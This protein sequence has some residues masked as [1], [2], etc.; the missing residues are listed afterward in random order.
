MKLFITTIRLK[1]SVKIPNKIIPLQCSWIRIYINSSHERKLF[2]QYL[3]EKSFVTSFKFHLNFFFKINKAKFSPSFFMEIIL[4]QKKHLAMMTET[5]SCILSQYLWYDE[6]TVSTIFSNL[7]YQNIHLCIFQYYKINH[8]NTSEISFNCFKQT[9]ASASETS[10]SKQLLDMI[11]A[12]VTL[13]WKL[14]SNNLMLSPFLRETKT[15]PEI[16]LLLNNIY[17]E[18]QMTE[19]KPFTISAT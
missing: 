11:S 4:N 13:K 12:K 16:E 3:T 8:S 14:I 6:S 2:P 5:P 17:T 1:D 9:L 19:P 18:V 15:A 10:A 7:Q